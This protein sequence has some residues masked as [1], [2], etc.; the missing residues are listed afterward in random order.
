V[1]YDDN[2]KEVFD[3]YRYHGPMHFLGMLTYPEPHWSETDIIVKELSSRS[4]ISL[5]D[6][7]CGLAQ[8][9][10]TLAEYLRDH[11]KTVTLTLADIPTLRQDFLVWWG[12]H[13]GIRTTFLPCNRE[14]PIPELPECDICQTTEFFEHVHNP[15]AYFDAINGKLSSKGLLVTG[16]MDHH[17]DFMHVSPN[18]GSLRSRIAECGY[19]TLV[20][21]RIF[22]KP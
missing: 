5:L 13:T 7:G 10:R 14:T 8:Q 18:L 2:E 11:G 3:T 16:T 6:F 15:V 9:S 17:S 1:F 22:R 12:E 20:T 19:E 4:T 21:D